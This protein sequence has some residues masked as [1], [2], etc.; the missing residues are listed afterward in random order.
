MSVSIST[1]YMQSVKTL[2]NCA[3][4]RSTLYV[5]LRF[6]TQTIFVSQCGGD[7]STSQMSC[8]DGQWGD[9]TPTFMKTEARRG[10]DSIGPGEAKSRVQKPTTI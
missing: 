9:V 7:L 10:R 1:I 5:S 6:D 3:S 4:F 2:R 8:S